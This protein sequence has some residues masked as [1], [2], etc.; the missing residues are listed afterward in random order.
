MNRF[1]TTLLLGLSG[2]AAAQVAPSGFPIT[3]KHDLGQPVTF[4][5]RPVRIVTLS[6]EQAELL[7]ALGVKPVG[8]A[9]GKIKAELGAKPAA[10][11]STPAATVLKDATYIGTFSQPST[12]LLASL[13][14]DLILMP[15]SEQ[16]APTYAA[17][18]RFAPTLGYD[19]DQE[20]WRGPLKDVGHL[21]SKDAA[22]AL[23]LNRFDRRVAQLKASL[24]AAVKDKSETTLLFMPG[25]GAVAVL[26][27]DYAFGKNLMSL[28]LQ[29]KSP[30]GLDPKAGFTPIAPEALLNTQTGRVVVMRRG[31]M[32]GEAVDAVFAKLQAKGIPVFTYA[33]DPQEAASGPLT[34]LQRMEKA[35]K[36]ITK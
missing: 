22:A 15:G 26:G 29:L 8:F 5:K 27:S 19:Y 7:A 9:S 13:K 10:N 3:L 34:D 32:S 4:N 17:V 18:S 20:S 1:V 21:L 23:F 35:V 11:L 31:A 28:G 24:P 36:L 25:N 16:M 30:P 12:E 2:L 14:P 33:I 6:E